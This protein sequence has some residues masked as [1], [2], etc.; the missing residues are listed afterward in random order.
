MGEDSV[1]LGLSGLIGGRCN[2]EELV[3]L[4]PVLAVFGPLQSQTA[5]E[6]EDR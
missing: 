1:L 5:V 4:T 3:A 6:Q 2:R